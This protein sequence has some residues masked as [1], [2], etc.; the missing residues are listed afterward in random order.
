MY[1]NVIYHNTSRIVAIVDQQW[2]IKIPQVKSPKLLILV[3]MWHM[4]QIWARKWG[5]WT[6]CMALT[7]QPHWYCQSWGYWHYW[8]PRI[9]SQIVNEIII[10]CV[11]VAIYGVGDYSVALLLWHFLHVQHNLYYQLSFCSNNHDWDILQIKIT[12]YE[13]IPG[14]GQ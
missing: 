7:F 5:R 2:I 13:D 6:V 12:V 4:G 3:N 10:S 8:L 11:Y 9:T 1:N 14:I